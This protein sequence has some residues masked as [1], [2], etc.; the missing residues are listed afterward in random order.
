MSFAPL[1]CESYALA[2]IPATLARPRMSVGRSVGYN[3]PQYT[4]KL[5]S[6][7]NWGD[8]QIKNV[9][10]VTET[11]VPVGMWAMLPLLTSS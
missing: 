5:R 6:G 7:N 11:S 10:P 8:G 1:F 4:H 9:G 2:H 3:P